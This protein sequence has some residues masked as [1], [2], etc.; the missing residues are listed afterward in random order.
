MKA[1]KRFKL[2]LV[3]SSVIL[4]CISEREMHLRLRVH[5]NGDSRLTRTALNTNTLQ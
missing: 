2:P 5:L 4:F 1:M 3:V